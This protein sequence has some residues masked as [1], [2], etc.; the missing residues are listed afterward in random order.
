M[1]CKA[2]LDLA[3]VRLTAMVLATVAVGYLLAS[4]QPVNWTRLLLTVFGSGLAAIGA[5]TLNQLLEMDR[6]AKMDRASRRPLPSGAISVRHACIFAAITVSA[7]L[8]LL[9]WSVNPLTALLGLGNVLFYLLAYTPL[10]S[11]TWLSTLVGAICGATPP[12]M[13][14]A[15]AAGQ[16]NP[17]AMLLAATIFVWQVPHFLSLAWLYRADYAKAGYRVLPTVDSSGRATC[18]AIAFFSLMLLPLGLAARLCGVV[19][20]LVGAA[21]RLLGCGFSC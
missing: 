16:V 14:S 5:G 19:N 1:L 9:C 10:K 4:P 2:Y 8:S 11:K 15:A 6:D 17:A 20:D 7:G 12:L 18:L 3:K 21:L 13:G